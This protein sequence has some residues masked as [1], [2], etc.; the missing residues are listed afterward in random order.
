MDEL[1]ALGVKRIS[2]GSALSRG[3]LGAFVR[4]AREIR[5]HGTFRFADDA[6]P[7]AQANDLV[8][9]KP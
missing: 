7:F 6:V 1:A 9:A 2:V 8:T 4:A 3:V 5:E